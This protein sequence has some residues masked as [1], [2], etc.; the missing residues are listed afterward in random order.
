MNRIPPHDDLGGVSAGRS[1]RRG[2][3]MLQVVAGAVVTQPATDV[4]GAVVVKGTAADA[5]GN[6]LPFGE[7]QQRMISKTLFNVNGRRDLRAPGDGTLA[8]DAPGSIHWTATYT[9]LSS[10]D[11][12]LT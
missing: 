12:A 7:L 1:A 5:A 9:G 8:Y 10:A 6:P 2:H 11:I 4:A 3:R